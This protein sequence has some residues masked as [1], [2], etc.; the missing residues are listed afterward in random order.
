[1]KS[2]KFVQKT[3]IKKEE[4]KSSLETAL[5]KSTN[6]HGDAS[7]RPVSGR[8][9]AYHA[10]DEKSTYTYGNASAR[11]MGRAAACHAEERSSTRQ[12]KSTYT[13]VDTSARPASG[14]ATALHA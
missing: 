8:A 6:T 1:M 3:K 13:P 2:E 10:E 9:A 5:P 7:A 14:H 11:P 12:L 4:E